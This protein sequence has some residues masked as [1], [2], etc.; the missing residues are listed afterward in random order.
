MSAP[1]QFRLHK[2]NYLAMRIK[3]WRYL[4]AAGHE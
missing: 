2:I 4:A 1:Y 3:K